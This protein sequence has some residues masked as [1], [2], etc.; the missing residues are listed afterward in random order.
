[1][2][3]SN[4]RRSV[5]FIAGD[6][7]GDACTAQLAERLAERHPDIVLHALGGRRLGGVVKRSGGTW[8]AD[9][10]N[11]SAIGLISVLLIYLRARWLS[12]KLHRFLHAHPIDAAVLCDWGGF[13]CRKL[14]FFRKAGVPT[15]YFFP[16]RSWQ[17]TGKAGLQF[18]PLVTRVATPFEWSAKRLSDAGCRADWVGHPL[19]ESV[20]GSRSRELLRREFG[21]EAGEKLVALLPGSRPSEIRV[22]G[23]R[24][25][26]AARVLSRDP[27]IKFL[28]PVPAPLVRMARAH[29]PPSIQVVVDRATDALLACDVAV[30]KTGSATLEAAVAGAPQVTVYDLGWVSRIEWL[31]LWMWKK[32]PFIAMPNI[33]LQRPLVPELLGLNCRPDAIAAGVK[34]LL[35]NKEDRRLMEEGYKEIRAHLGENLPFRATG[36]TVEILEEMLGEPPARP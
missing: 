17:R 8:I 26:A 31:L 22:L 14:T 24:L 28:V 30:V 6:L 20:R 11:C 16:P 3:G 4:H 32:I 18:A 5:L 33:I 13:N 1:M 35:E 25:A 27:S 36:R 29:F 7:S 9:T 34:R 15:L 19:L 12:F 23:P 21:V 2:P 10:T